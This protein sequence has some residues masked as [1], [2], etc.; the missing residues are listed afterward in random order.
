MENTVNKRNNSIDIFRYLCALLIVAIHVH[1]LMQFGSRYNIL[2]VDYFTRIGVPF[3]F[4]TAGYFYSKKLLD[5]KKPFKNYIIKLLKIYLFWSAVYA[6]FSV[7]KT[8]SENKFNGEAAKELILG[9]LYRGVSEHL[10]FVPSLVVA[11]CVL[12]LFNKLN[13]MKILLPILKVK[14]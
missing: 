13:A 7:V 5:G 2:F 1:P 10:W 4:V 9:F 12:T 11:I 6:V 8:L 14:I 3:F